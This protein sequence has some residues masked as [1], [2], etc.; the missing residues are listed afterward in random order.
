MCLGVNFFGFILT[1]IC[2]APCMPFGRVGKLSGII[3][4][5]ALS[6]FSSLSEMLITRML[7]SLVTV[8]QDSE[9]LFF[10]FSSLFFLCCS[11]LVN[12]HC[13]VS[14]HLLLF[15]PFVPFILLLNTWQSFLFWLPH[16]SVSKLPLGFSLHL[17][18][19]C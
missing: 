17:L 5:P 13:F 16:F 4:F 19:V 6:S 12:F 8:L 1:E 10:F 18:F 15:F 14:V 11:G 9:A 7:R 2:C 3:S